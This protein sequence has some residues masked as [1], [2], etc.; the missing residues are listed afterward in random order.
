[1]SEDNQNDFIKHDVDG[2]RPL[3]ERTFKF[4]WLVGKVVLILMVTGVVLGFLLPGWH[5]IS[6]KERRT[7]KILNEACGFYIKNNHLAVKDGWGNYL[8]IVSNE[9]EIRKL[10]INTMRPSHKDAKFIIYS[11]GP[12]GIDEQGT[13]DDLVVSDLLRFP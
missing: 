7:R 6:R 3:K 8:K 1:M 4:G 11:F 2:S 10:K 9:Q 12:N 5:H 13:E